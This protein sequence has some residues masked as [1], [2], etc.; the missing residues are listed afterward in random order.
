MFRKASRFL[1]AIN[2]LMGDK[3]D[4]MVADDMETVGH[5]MHRWRWIA[6]FA[7]V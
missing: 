6:I 7:S 4:D 1:A 5:M 2:G 3:H